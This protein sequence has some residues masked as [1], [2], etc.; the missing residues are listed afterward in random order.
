[1]P[2]SPANRVQ[3]LVAQNHRFKQRDT[4]HC[5]LDKWG[6]SQ[7]D[8]SAL[9][10]AVWLERTWTQQGDDR[11][12]RAGIYHHWQSASP[13]SSLAEVSLS[14]CPES[15]KDAPE[16]GTLWPEQRGGATV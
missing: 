13:S 8:G 12:R 4:P 6:N 11:R 10:D 16:D 5:D 15:R 2:A 7:R 9:Y 14:L 3:A 1:M